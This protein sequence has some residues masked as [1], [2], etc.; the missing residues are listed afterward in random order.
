MNILLLLLLRI[1]TIINEMSEYV[2][3][4]MGQSSPLGAFW[5]S[6]MSCK[7]MGSGELHRAR[8]L[9]HSERA[10]SSAAFTNSS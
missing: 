4:S 10:V 9:Q 5:L 1:I 2:A 3:L 6:H 7:L 8:E